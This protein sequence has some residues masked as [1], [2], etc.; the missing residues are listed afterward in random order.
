[1]SANVFY[2]VRKTRRGGV[3]EVATW[4]DEVAAAM[5]ADNRQSTAR[6]GVTFEV[7]PA[8]IVVPVQIRFPKAR[9]A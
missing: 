7:D 3:K 8:E 6:R 9:V 4:L 5:D 1:M 2:V